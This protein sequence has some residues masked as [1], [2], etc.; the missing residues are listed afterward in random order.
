MALGLHTLAPVNAV[1]PLPADEVDRLQRLEA[2]GLDLTPDP[3]FDALTRLARKVCD[4]PMAALTF[5]GAEHVTCKSASGFTLGTHPRGHSLCAHTILGPGALIIED[6]AAD[7]RLRCPVEGPFVLSYA[8]VP[9]GHTPEG[10]ALGA[11]CVFDVVPREFTAEQRALLVDLGRTA[12]ELLFGEPEVHRR[13]RER[14]DAEAKARR[15]LEARTERLKMLRDIAAL[16]ATELEPMDA[17]RRA[18]TLVAQ[19]SPRTRASWSS[20]DAHSN[21]ETLVSCGPPHMKD[22]TGCRGT[23]AHA[24]E[25]LAALRAGRPVVTDDVLQEPSMQALAVEWTALD[26]RASVEFVVESSPGTSWLVCL[27]SP[28]PIAWEP[29]FVE[30]ID[31]VAHQLALVLRAIEARA[32]SREAKNELRATNARL[33]TVLGS[34]QGGVLVTDEQRR[35]VLVNDAYLR[36]GGLPQP[37]DSFIGLTTTEAFGTVTLEQFGAEAVQVARQRIV[38]GK[39]VYGELIRHRDGRVYERDY[40]PVELDGR[41][42]GHLWQHREVTERVKQYEQLEAARNAALEAGVAKSAFLAT[43]SHEIRTPLNG[44]LGTLTLLQDGELA[45]SQ[46]ELTSTALDSADQLLRLLNDILDASKMEA[47]KLSLE[48]APFNPRAAVKSAGALFHSP[49]EQKGLS[50]AVKVHDA[51]PERVLGDVHRFRQVVTNLVSN[52][53]KFTEQGDV[54]VELDWRD[55]R[56]LL[57]VQDTGPGVPQ[58]KRARLFEKFLQGDAST[59]RRYGGSGLGLAICADL[60]ELM[61]G[62]LR[63][64]ESPVGARFEVELPLS[65]TSHGGGQTPVPTRVRFPG[66]S[67]LV[68]DDNAV[69]RMVAVAHLQKLGCEVASVNDGLQAVTLVNEH[70]ERFDLVFMDCHMPELDG[71]EA[72]RRL[73]ARFGPE[74]LA[75]VALT[76][77]ALEEDTRRCH[78]AGM[79]SVLAKPVRRDDFIVELSRVYSRRRQR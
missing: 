72:T 67:V 33:K 49:A 47:G 27:D 36:M 41:G 1:F 74:Q 51:V 25:H 11:L 10:S 79:E 34:L 66:L 43:M 15:A 39:A 31:E 57:V 61:G 3:R 73:R 35:V 63:L 46:R 54:R 17:V 21:Y 69:N 52:A 23:L 76:A 56:L 77:S 64:A 9:L 65:Q 7:G 28:E 44:V 5:V 20:L 60:V 37:A 59:T 58:A 22:S 4:T 32:R 38:E 18:L 45:P 40:V 6:A 78:A 8:G 68:V 70:P 75:I 55:T 30:V 53:V 62:A 71:F 26:V 50:L 24:P 12:E 16:S 19:F 14:I 2:L 42:A 13:L 29:E 48:L